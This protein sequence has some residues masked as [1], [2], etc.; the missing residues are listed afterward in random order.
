[1]PRIANPTRTQQVCDRLSA[2]YADEPVDIYVKSLPR[3]GL[4]IA[5]SHEGSNEVGILFHVDQVDNGASGFKDEA[6]R[7]INA[8]RDSEVFV[9]RA[10]KGLVYD[11]I[12]T[13]GSPE[14]INGVE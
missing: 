6:L 3:Q 14:A 7:R 2:Y 13:Y 10:P 5:V 8:F 4:Y 9:P 12:M 1:M 11:D